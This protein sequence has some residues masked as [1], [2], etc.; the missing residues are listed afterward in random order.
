MNKKKV[1]WDKEN[2]NG[3]RP[4]HE[5]RHRVNGGVISVTIW[6][7]TVASEA[8][9][10]K[11]L[12]VSFSRSYHDGKDWVDTKSMRVQDLPALVMITQEA[13]SYCQQEMAQT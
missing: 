1:D 2:S 9:Q 12:N 8:N 7:N 5:I 13:Y 4:V 10:R 3:K 11:F 6:S